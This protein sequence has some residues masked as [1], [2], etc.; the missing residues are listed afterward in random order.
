MSEIRVSII[1]PHYRRTDNINLLLQSLARQTDTDYEVI[2]GSMEYDP[3]FCEICQR[4][5][6]KVDIISVLSSHPWKVSEAR[7]LALRQARGEIIV[8]VDA[9]MI[10]PK[11]FISLIKTTYSWNPQVCVIGQMI[12]YDNNESDVESVSVKPFS[13]YNEL[14]ES[15][16]K[17]PIDAIDM[18][19]KEYW[20]IPFSYAW[21]ALV[22]LPRQIIEENA[23]YFNE[24]YEG[25]GV[26][27]LEWG[28]RVMNVGT[29][30]ILEKDVWGIHLPHVRD[31][32][33]NRKSETKNYLRFLQQYP[34]KAVE[35]MC[36]LGDFAAN[37][38]YP[39]LTHE[40]EEVLSDKSH[41]MGIVLTENDGKQIICVGAELNATGHP[42]NL[43]SQLNDPPYRI[44]TVW[45]LIGLKVPIQDNS[46]DEYVTLSLFN[47]LST[48]YQKAILI[49][50]E[51]VKAS[52]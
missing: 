13:E 5:I 2:I 3:V 32:A 48:S 27:D 25:Y 12:D 38:E 11:K 44:K 52:E 31:T 10:V 18:R 35:L 21:T 30:F 8:F 14:L 20:S 43:A 29:P 42:I 24:E 7:N 33:K 34:N 39:N 28:Y 23:L 41:E 40:I 37:R 9:D 26:E 15:L 49:E 17:N 47:S 50:M 6:D 45:P 36:H 1:V 4:Y 51:R 46:V 19:W 22:A 16:E